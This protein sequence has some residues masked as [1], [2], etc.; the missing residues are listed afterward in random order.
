MGLFPMTIF[1]MLATGALTIFLY[2]PYYNTQ[3]I[4]SFTSILVVSAVMV[5]YPTSWLV[6]GCSVLYAAIVPTPV[7]GWVLKVSG[8]KGEY[9]IFPLIMI[10][11]SG[12][13]IPW[14]MF[15]KL[16]LVP[17]GG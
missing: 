16:V 1:A 8:Y 10:A 6:V 9:C 17:L 13:A 7:T 2:Y 4:L 14:C 11:V 15:V 5:T 3:P 12:V